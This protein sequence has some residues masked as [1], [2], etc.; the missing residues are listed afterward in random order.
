MCDTKKFALL[1]SNFENYKILFVTFTIFTGYSFFRINVIKSYGQAT[2]K[3]EQ[4]PNLSAK[5]FFL[6]SIL[7]L[8]HV[9]IE[10]KNVFALSACWQISLLFCNNVSFKFA[11]A[12]TF[13]QYIFIKPIKSC[14]N[15]SYFIQL[16]TQ[17]FNEK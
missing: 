16:Y 4:E 6:D 2:R 10:E 7:I 5:R 1:S 12:L 17:N 8:I 14:C 13:S 15:Q 9:L 3:G 11:F